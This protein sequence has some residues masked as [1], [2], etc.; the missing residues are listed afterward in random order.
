MMTYRDTADVVMQRPSVQLVC[1]HW[2]ANPEHRRF[3]RRAIALG[4]KA[5][6]EKSVYALHE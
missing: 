6:K 5:F 3:G 2:I 1:K 4:S